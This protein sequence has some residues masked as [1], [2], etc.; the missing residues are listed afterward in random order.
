VAEA[1]TLSITTPTS[2]SSVLYAKSGSQSLPGRCQG[3]LPS[4]S[5]TKCELKASYTSNVRPRCPRSLPPNASLIKAAYT[6]KL[7]AHTLV[8]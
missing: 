5:A 3:S 2:M 8:T 6:S 1:R 4:L 7:R